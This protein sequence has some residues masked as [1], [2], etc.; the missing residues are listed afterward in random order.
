MINYG[1]AYSHMLTPKKL[2][3][4]KK[5]PVSFDPVPF[6]DEQ[7]F[8]ESTEVQL[9]VALFSEVESAVSLTDEELV[10]VALLIEVALLDSF[11]LLVVGEVGVSATK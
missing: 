3:V 6:D 1:L 11:V 5:L 9:A 2:P 4:V 7:L 8:E 10:L